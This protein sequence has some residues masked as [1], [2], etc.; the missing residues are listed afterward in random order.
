MNA[1]GDEPDQA[2]PD[3][4]GTTQTL[5]PADPE[6]RGGKGRLGVLR[7]GHRPGRD[8]R[9]TTHVCLTSRALGAD[10]VYLH[11]PDERIVETVRSVV[12]RFGGPFEVEAVD[13]WR[14]VLKEWKRQGAV[15]VHLTMYGRPVGEV[16]PEVSLDADVLVVV[17]AEKV[18]FEVYEAADYNI[19]VGSQ[20]HSEVAAMAVLL[21]RFFGG[22]WENKPFEGEVQVVPSD[23]G[24]VALTRKDTD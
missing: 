11:E 15:I 2:P 12:R 8:K 4:A 17:G 13:S 21:D 7:L 16:L 24:K 14:A 5:P 20:P 22:R 3:V 6:W 9:I 19:A 10:I 18:P 1:M 23:C